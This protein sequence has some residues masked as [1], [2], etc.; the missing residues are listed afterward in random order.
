MTDS[1]RDQ[2][3]AKLATHA[4]RQMD[5]I[6]ALEVVVAAMLRIQPDQGLVLQEI[7]RVLEQQASFVLEAGFTKDLPPRLPAE[8]AADTRKAV[9]RWLRRYLSE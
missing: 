7:E 4:E 8:M 1:N 9:E 5:K 3:L 2:V 6:A